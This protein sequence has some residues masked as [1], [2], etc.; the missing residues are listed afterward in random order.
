[1]Y[2]L[3]IEQKISNLQE[4]LGP[5]KKKLTSLQKE[6]EGIESKIQRLKLAQLKA[7]QEKRN[8]KDPVSSYSSQG[9]EV[10]SSRS[11]E[12]L[13]EKTNLF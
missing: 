4:L 12:E 13:C 2:K 5:K 10:T 6:I 1:M 7:E 11:Q 9:T 3:T 8:E